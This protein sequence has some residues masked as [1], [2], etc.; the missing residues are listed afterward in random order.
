MTDFDEIVTNI[1]ESS[2]GAIAAAIM[3]YDGVPLAEYKKSES[4]IDISTM[5][6][7]YMDV[8][9]EIKSASEVLEAGTMEEITVRSDELVFIVRLINE[10]FFLALI[11]TPDGNCG[12]GRY[13]TRIAAPK[14]AEAV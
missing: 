13:L 9:K 2:Q 12:K 7:E 8:L 10:E 4:E 14:V 11:L 6:I 3:A 1:V 5:S